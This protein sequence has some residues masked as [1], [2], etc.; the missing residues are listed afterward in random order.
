M[1]TEKTINEKKKD[2]VSG[3]D[4]PILRIG[5]SKKEV[6]KQYKTFLKNIKKSKK[7]WIILMKETKS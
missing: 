5:L 6:D 2:K 7:H 1:V 4:I 3:I